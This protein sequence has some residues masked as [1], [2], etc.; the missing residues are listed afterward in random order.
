M[1]TRRSVLIAAAAGLAATGG[2]LEFAAGTAPLRTQATRATVA[3]GALAE[4]GYEVS[5]SERREE[6][7]TVTTAGQSR[8]I[9]AACYVSEY[10][11]RL[12]TGAITDEYLGTVSVTSA[13][14]TELFGRTSHPLEGL[15]DRQ[16]ASDLQSEYE[17]FEEIE[18][19]ETDEVSLLGVRRDVDVYR[20]ETEKAGE[21]IDVIVH[22]LSIDHGEDHLVGVGV[23]PASLSGEKQRIRTL[24]KRI[25]YG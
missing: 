14:R 6:T 4:T 24:L 9:E 17:G 18:H 19:V 21:L 3:D 12:S 7:Y 23:H 1:T 13:P 16:L 11:R 2:C 22:L 5:R 20:A 10:R 25:E 15:S 8:K